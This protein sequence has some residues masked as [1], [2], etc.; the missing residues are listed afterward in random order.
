M[1]MDNETKKL[2]GTAFVLIGIAA[3]GVIAWSYIEYLTQPRGGWHWTTGEI[4]QIISGLIA[5]WVGIQIKTINV[6]ENNSSK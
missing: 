6:I 3:V 2:V 5:I 4:F 1:G